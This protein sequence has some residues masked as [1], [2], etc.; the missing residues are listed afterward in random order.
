MSAQGLCQPTPAELRERRLGELC[1][2][3]LNH[4]DLLVQRAG[5]VAIDLSPIEAEALELFAFVFLW[6]RL[7]RPKNGAA[8][9][10]SQIEPGGLLAGESGPEVARERAL[11]S[12]QATRKLA[13][14]RRHG[15]PES[16]PEELL[17]EA[18]RSFVILHN[19]ASGGGRDALKI[20]SWV[21]RWKRVVPMLREELASSRTDRFRPGHVVA[22]LVALRVFYRA[23]VEGV[24]SVAV[25]GAGC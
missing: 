10:G 4:P 18:A 15:C 13:Q 20:D 9:F 7:A 12:Q 11:F 6:G 5:C 21:A 25:I 17:I 8:G 16:D 19:L 23:A 1:D 14:F 3:A 2:L 22:D 24:L